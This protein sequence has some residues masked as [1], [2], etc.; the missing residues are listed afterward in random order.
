MYVVLLLQAN[1]ANTSGEEQR[2]RLHGRVALLLNLISLF[3]GIGV[4]VGVGVYLAVVLI[5]H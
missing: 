2:A 3:L 5:I 1:E 4:Y